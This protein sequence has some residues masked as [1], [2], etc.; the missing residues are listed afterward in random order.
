MGLLCG[1]LTSCGIFLLFSLENIVLM[2][3]SGLIL[4]C[5]AVVGFSM[6]FPLMGIIILWQHTLQTKESF[7][8]ACVVVVLDIFLGSYS[9]YKIVSSLILVPQIVFRC[10]QVSKP[11]CC[12]IL[13]ACLY[14]GYTMMV[15]CS[16]LR[17]N[18]FYGEPST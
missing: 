6:M 3:D 9:W 13:M 7:C 8:V 2:L 16:T 17:D 11:S 15:L 14:A 4:F 1:K 18:F 10:K 12:E 5:T